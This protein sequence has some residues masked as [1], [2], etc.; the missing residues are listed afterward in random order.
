[1]N[2]LDVAILDYSDLEREYEG[3]TAVAEGKMNIEIQDELKIG[4]RCRRFTVEA[5]CQVL[6]VEDEEDLT[7][8]LTKM[9]VDRYDFKHFDK[10]DTV[11]TD[12]E[13]SVLISQLDS[14]YE[15]QYRQLELLVSQDVR[16]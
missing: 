10:D 16:L 6:L 13:E 8:N 15:E 4:Y 1:M 7:W 9:T 3:E 5:T 12:D 2:T 11:I 14:T